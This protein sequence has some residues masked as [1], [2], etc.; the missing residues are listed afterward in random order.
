[1][2]KP[3][4]LLVSVGTP[5]TNKALELRMADTPFVRDVEIT[6][7]A[8]I[9]EGGSPPYTFEINSGVEPDGVTFESNGKITGTPTTQGYTETLVQ[10]TDSASNTFEAWFTIDVKGGIVIQ[11]TLP[12]ACVDTAYSAL[13]VATGGVLPYA[14][15]EVSSGALPDGLSIVYEGGDWYIVGTPTGDDI[16]APQLVPFTL[17]VTDDSGNFTEAAFQMAVWNLMTINTSFE[18]FTYLWA[19]TGFSKTYTPAWGVISASNP[20]RHYRLPKATFTVESDSS[21]DGF[22][23]GLSVGSLTG[24]V[25]GFPESPGFNYLFD[26]VATDQFGNT[27]SQ[28]QNYRVQATATPYMIISEPFG[29]GSSTH[30]E[31]ET[32]YKTSFNA[33]TL[34]MTDGSEV[35][36]VITRPSP[37]P[38]D[39]LIVAADF[40]SPPGINSFYFSLIG[41]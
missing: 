25:S 33:Q 11:T 17:K 27:A 39:N 26:V 3:L 35:A 19:N 16:T 9:A 12:Y 20:L 1:M 7:A 22:P 2:K 18:E 5:T 41:L 8:F 6:E 31:Y 29:D 4:I 34:K 13:L 38:G 21:S 23:N 32:T 36:S 40:V 30:F 14:S 15:W 24:T 10:V 28:S 37:S